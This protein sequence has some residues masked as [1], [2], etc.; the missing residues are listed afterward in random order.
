MNCRSLLAVSAAVITLPRVAI[1]QEPAPL[2]VV[3]AGSMGA[4]MEGPIKTQS[5]AALGVAYHGRGQ[6]SDA[7]AQLIV[8]GSITPDVFIPVTN[9]PMMTVLKGG[10]ATMGVPVARTEMVIAYSPKSTYAQA[11]ADAAAG[12]RGA[13]PWWQILTQP[14]L[15]FG[16]TDPL[17]DPQGRNI[18]FTLQLAE[19]FYKQPGLARKITGQPINPAQVFAEPTVEARLQSGELDAGSAYK[20]QPSPLNIPFVTLPPEIN[21]A[22]DAMRARYAQATLDLNGKTFHPDPLVYY[23]AVLDGAAHR[24]KAAAF[25]SWL[26]GPGAAI[27]KQYFYDPPTGAATLRGLRPGA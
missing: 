14:D 2:E 12:K 20:I 19:S 17:T 5:S 16:R 13:M 4:M 10:K 1:A 21:L 7:L 15:R 8:G 18:L 25:V 22:S 24:E 6:G 3:Y 26:T 11:F 9:A 23:A 27:F